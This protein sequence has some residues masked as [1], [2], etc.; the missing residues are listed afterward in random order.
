MKKISSARVAFTVVIAVL[1]YGCNPVKWIPDGS[2]L[3]KRNV[4]HLD[5][6][7]ELKE[8]LNTLIKQKP[9]RKLLGVFYP[10][11]WFY[12]KG[13]SG[14]STGFKRWLKEIGEEPSILDTALTHRTANQLKLFMWKHGFFN[15]EV[16]DSFRTEGRFA[17]SEYVITSGTP[18]TVGSI[19][20]STRDSM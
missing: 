3:L 11:V 13:S 6:L 20:Y 4:I 8:Q 10:Y 16:V 5:T 17:I 12:Q 18:Y 14:K 2:F 1:V 15:A 19:D 7:H 9:N